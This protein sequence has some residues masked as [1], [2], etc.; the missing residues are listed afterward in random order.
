[1]K[2]CWVTLP[3]MPASSKSFSLEM[4]SLIMAFDPSSLIAADLSKIALSMISRWIMNLQLVELLFH[5]LKYFYQLQF[6][7]FNIIFKRMQGYR[8]G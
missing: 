3:T 2:K 1:M 4:K 5:H 8:L 6:I 7:M